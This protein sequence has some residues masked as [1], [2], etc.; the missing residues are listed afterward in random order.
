MSSSFPKSA[1]WF[2]LNN[3]NY[4]LYQKPDNEILYIHKNS[5]YT[6]SIL[7]QIPTSIEK[8]IS[9]LSSNKTIFNESKEIYQ[10]ALEKSSYLQSLK[11]HPVNENVSNNK[12]NRKQNVIWF[13]PSFS[14]NV[15]TKVGN[16]FLNLRRKHFPSRHKLFNHNTMEVSYSCM[17]NIKAEIHKHNKSTIEKAQ[18]KHPNTRLYN[19]TNKKQ[20]PLNDQCLTES[21]V[22]QANITTSIPC[23]KEDNI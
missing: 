15:K 13:N 20:C 22:Y 17:P 3:S 21:I 5:N 9:T 11:Y 16:Y 18:Q 14:V 2:N 1:Q 10:K 12:Q 19:C 23:Y 7:K 4:K 6:P 8:R